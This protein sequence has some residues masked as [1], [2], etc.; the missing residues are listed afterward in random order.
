[1][2]GIDG[3]KLPQKMA[4]LNTILDIIPDNLTEEVLIDFLNDL[5]A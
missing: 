5:F 2:V 3:T 4:L 1:M